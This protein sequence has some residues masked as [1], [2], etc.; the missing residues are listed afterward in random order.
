MGSSSS[1]P[2]TIN[3][4]Q[5][6]FKFFETQLRPNH[7][8]PTETQNLDEST[9]PSYWID[10]NNSDDNRKDYLVLQ[11]RSG[12]WIQKRSHG[13]AVAHLDPEICYT[14][15]THNWNGYS[16]T[17]PSLFVAQNSQI[18]LATVPPAPWG[19]N[20]KYK[21]ILDRSEIR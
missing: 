15:K 19:G 5:L 10:A 9:T 1:S 20:V 3:N 6:W 4:T 18:N 2:N 16:W 11:R 13:K 21:K 7:R 12:V 8:I 17:T 14:P